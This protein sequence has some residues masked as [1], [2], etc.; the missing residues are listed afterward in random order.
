MT[1]TAHS[2][3]DE[4]FD[5]QKANTNNRQ[6]N[7]R[8]NSAQAHGGRMRTRHGVQ[9]GKNDNN[10]VYEWFTCIFSFILIVCL[11]GNIAEVPWCV[12]MH[13]PLLVSRVCYC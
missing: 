2:Y 6:I 9:L 3:D 7:C 10:H 1:G 12:V 4:W 5:W 11:A 8:G 13:S